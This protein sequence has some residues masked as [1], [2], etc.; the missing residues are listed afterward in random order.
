MDLAETS[1]FS[2]SPGVAGQRLTA[3]SKSRAPAEPA[4][5]PEPPRSC[6]DSSSPGHPPS[7][8]ELQ[9]AVAGTPQK[10]SILKQK[11]QGWTSLGTPLIH[12]S[13]VSGP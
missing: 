1:I 12:G 13:E 7:N 5:E 3:G 2:M 8:V 11:G 4:A 6:G 10:R 9:N